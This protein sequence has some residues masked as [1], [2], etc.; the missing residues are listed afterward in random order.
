MVV[1]ITTIYYFCIMNEM[2]KQ[3]TNYP[4]YEISNLG[5]V[6]SIKNNIIL[7]P[8]QCKNGYLMVVLFCNKKGKS[9]YIHKLVATHFIE[10]SN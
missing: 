4:N 7:K 8:S 9:N 5:N 6:Y 3:I 1:I 2:W 10:K